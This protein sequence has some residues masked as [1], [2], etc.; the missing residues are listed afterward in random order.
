M[1][2]FLLSHSLLCQVILNTMQ[3]LLMMGRLPRRAFALK[4]IN[5]CSVILFVK[6]Y[7]DVDKCFKYIRYVLFFNVIFIPVTRRV[8][9]YTRFVGKYVTVG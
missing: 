4:D 5:I 8:K 7:L 3:W 9:G 1:G 6:L 2:I